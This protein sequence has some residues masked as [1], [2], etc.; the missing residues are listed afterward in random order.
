[1]KTNCDS[2]PYILCVW[3]K[4]HIHR[5]SSWK[6]NPTR[7]PA[8]P[9]ISQFNGKLVLIGALIAI[10]CLAWPNRNKKS[11]QFTGL[12]R[13][14]ERRWPLFGWFIFQSGMKRLGKHS[15]IQKKA[16]FLIFW[17]GKISHALSGDNS[18]LGATGKNSYLGVEVRNFHMGGKKSHIWEVKNRTIGR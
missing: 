6:Y 10:L 8:F 1:M 11:S 3:R 12:L 4:A 9:Y 2:E 18:Y 17:E 5:T 16:R 7:S 15:Q 14:M 13:E